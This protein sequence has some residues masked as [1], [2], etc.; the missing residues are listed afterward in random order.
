M[1]IHI[2][3]YLAGLATAEVDATE[4]YGHRLDRI[5]VIADAIAD[6]AHGD[7]QLAAFLAVQAYAESKLSRESQTCQC[8][9][10]SCDHG[11]A[12]S[13]WNLH[14][15]WSMPVETW[16][17]YCGESYAAVRASAE[18]Q[19][20][21]YDPRSLECSFARC[22]GAGVPCDVSWAVQRARETRRVAVMM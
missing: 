1:S 21:Y 11:R 18:R 17:S 3:L 4:D 9:R 22:G 14:R 12:H 5:S 19:R 13:V 16:W 10:Y 2:F 8:K 6:T 20:V 15:V 7:R